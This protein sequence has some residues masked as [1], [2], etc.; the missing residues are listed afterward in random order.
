VGL[1]MGTGAVLYR[2]AEPGDW[3]ALVALLRACQLPTDDLAAALPH[4]FVANA[5]GELIGSAGL[6]IS[7]AHALFRSLAVVPAWRGRGLS[8]R[9]WERARA[10]A[11]EAGV[12]RVFLLTTT[13]EPLFA[14]WGFARTPR[15]TAPED[16]RAAPEFTTLCSSSAAFMSLTLA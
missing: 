5:D 15:E 10:E 1:T 11:L 8:R 4:F 16:I 9:L 12:R 7:G 2:R 13:A 14:K 6:E 3:Q